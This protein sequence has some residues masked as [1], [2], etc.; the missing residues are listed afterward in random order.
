[1]KSYKERVNKNVSKF[2]FGN[3]VIDQGNKLQEEVINVN[4]IYTFKI[5]WTITS[6]SFW[7]GN[8]LFAQSPSS[9]VGG[10]YCLTSVRYIFVY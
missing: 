6:G 5:C 2:S 1:M 3:R 7:G 8:E 9:D 4:C 10:I